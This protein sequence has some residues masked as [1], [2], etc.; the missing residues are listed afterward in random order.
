M[1]K[2]FDFPI[3]KLC[4]QI[5]SKVTALPDNIA[6][7]KTAVTDMA[8]YVATNNT[9]NK[10]GIIS[11]KL[12]YLIN[13]NETH[14]SVERSTAGTQNWTCPAGVYFVFV[15][16][17]GGSGGGGG[18]GGGKVNAMKEKA[19]GSGGG[20]GGSG[21]VVFAIIPVTPGKV[22]A[23]TVGAGGAGG[24]GGALDTNDNATNGGNG[25]TTKFADILSV[26]GGIGGAHGL[27]G[28]SASKYDNVVPPNGGKGGSNAGSLTGKVLLINEKI[29]P[30]GKDGSKGSVNNSTSDT[31]TASGGAA[32][33]SM[34]GIKSGAG[35]AGGKTTFYSAVGGGSA[36]SAGAAGGAGYIKAIW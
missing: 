29:S 23:L 9:A 16:A 6:A 11:Q 13:L 8:K 15:I 21:N 26:T 2:P 34:L 20:S 3:H 35:G 10:T 19:S 30:S 12:T 7:V 31:G 33:T 1:G 22:Y 25:G 36:G 24:A 28:T 14:G 18:G 32:V 27:L 5:L 17:A 4:K